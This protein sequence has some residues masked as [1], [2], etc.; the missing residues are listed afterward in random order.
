[1]HLLTKDI[2]NALKE[3]IPLFKKYI[4]VNVQLL[5]DYILVLKRASCLKNERIAL[6]KFV[7][8]LRFF[9]QSLHRTMFFD[10]LHSRKDDSLLHCVGIIGA[11]FVKCLETLDLLYFFLTKPLQTEILSK[12]LN[13][14]LI[15]K[16][17]T[18]V[19]LE[20]TF[21]YFVK[22]TQ[23]LLE[24]L[25][26]NDPLY[27][28]EIIHFSVKYAVEEGIDIDD[29]EDILPFRCNGNPKWRMIS[30]KMLLNGKG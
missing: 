7:K 18:V 29:T 17:S 21:S 11:Y 23:W 26:L 22:F 9:S 28:I 25:G 13:E 12:T 14:K 4:S 1:M 3:L 5:N 19:N 6:I 16:D 2:E 30:I 20:D 8:K 15:L 10:D 24:S 27:Q